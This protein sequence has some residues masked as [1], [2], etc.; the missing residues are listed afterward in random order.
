MRSG[1]PYMKNLYQENSATYNNIHVFDYHELVITDDNCKQAN[2]YS[3]NCTCL[4]LDDSATRSRQ[5]SPCQAQQ[6]RIHKRNR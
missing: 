4:K 2:V 6:W 3:N 5:C 1:D